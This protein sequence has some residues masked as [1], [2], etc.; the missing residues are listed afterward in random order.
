MCYTIFTLNLKPLA[1]SPLYNGLSSFRI[2]GIITTSAQES[3]VTPANVFNQ[4]YQSY[5][6][7]LA[8]IDL[9]TLQDPLKITCNVRG[10]SIPF[11][12]TNYH[13]SPEGV[14]D[15]HGNKP[16]FGVSVILFKYLLMGSHPKTDDNALVTFRDF[17]DAAPLVHYFTNTVEGAIARHF[18]GRPKDLSA[19]CEHL[20]GVI[21]SDD[22]SY[23]V[24]YRIDALPQIPVYLLYNDAEEGFTARA[25]VLFQKN[26]E[27]YLDMESVA[28]IG[29]ELARLLEKQ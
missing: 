8:D 3:P 7:Q 9:A 4:T 18:T 22:W 27:S 14:A 28:M 20:G 12:G 1:A 2:K 15:E 25:V 5:L 13:I 6:E 11:L 21:C 26:T 23:Q 10:A 29:G 17:K 24:K 19:G 16:H